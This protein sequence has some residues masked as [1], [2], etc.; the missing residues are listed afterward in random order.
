MIQ[1]MP[2][3]A[4]K[5]KIRMLKSFLKCK[6]S[7]AWNKIYLNSKK[8]YDIHLKEYLKL[9]PQT[10]IEMIHNLEEIHGKSRRPD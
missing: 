2:S 4:Q 5:Q 9:H 1:M 7:P 3:K 8:D 10:I 6:L